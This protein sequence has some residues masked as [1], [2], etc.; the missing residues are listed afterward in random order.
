MPHCRRLESGGVYAC[1]VVLDRSEHQAYL[2]VGARGDGII[3]AVQLARGHDLVFQSSI[4]HD[5]PLSEYS[6]NP[7]Y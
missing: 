7:C 5:I 1:D 6:V 2:P 3:P 4:N